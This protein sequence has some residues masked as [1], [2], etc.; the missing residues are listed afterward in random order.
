VFLFILNLI[1]VYFFAMSLAAGFWGLFM[2]KGH[3]SRKFTMIIV[4]IGILAGLYF[5]GASLEYNEYYSWIFLAIII[6]NIIAQK[7]HINKRR[8]EY[9][10]QDM[11]GEMQHK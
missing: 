3:L 1:L 7:R 9:A 11:F 5:W 2:P 10:M 8:R 6:W 4:T